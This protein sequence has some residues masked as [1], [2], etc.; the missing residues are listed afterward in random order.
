MFHAWIEPNDRILLKQASKIDP[1][2][3][4][5]NAAAHEPYFY[6]SFSVMC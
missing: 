6:S 1:V 5:G 4:L 2:N 3:F